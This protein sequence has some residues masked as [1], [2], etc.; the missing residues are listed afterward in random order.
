MR[1]Y[2][3]NE[4]ISL[5]DII[6]ECKTFY[7]VGQETTSMMLSWTSFLLALN[8]EWQ[9]K[10]RLEILQLF[11]DRKRLT[12]EDFSAIAKLRKMTMVI[13]ES[14][15]L[16]PPVLAIFRTVAQDCKVGN[17]LLPKG[18]QIQISTL[19]LHHNRNIWGEDAQLFLPERF[20]GNISGGD[21]FF[22]FGV[23]PRICVGQG[24]AMLEAKLALAMI[25]QRYSFTRVQRL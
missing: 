12:S 2:R 8:P 18:M 24:L 10:I 20:A 4:S 11:R 15:R 7:F 22:P 5:D 9:E 1:A 3:E 19:V 25:L 17:V 6:D 23:G 21:A 14:M 16:Y 13:N